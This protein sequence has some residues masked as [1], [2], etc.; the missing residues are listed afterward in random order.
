MNFKKIASLLVFICLGINFVNAQ[1]GGTQ[2]R[3]GEQFNEVYDHNWSIGA[4]VNIVED[5][6]KVI[7][8][9]IDPGKYWNFS[10]PFYVNAEY[11]LNNKFSFNA[12]ISMNQYNEGKHIDHV[13]I[14]EGHEASYFAVD[15]AAK[16]YFRDLIKTYMFD[17]YVFAGFGFTNIGNYKGEPVNEYNLTYPDKIE[18]DADGN[19]VVPAIGRMT[20]NAGIGFNFWFSQNWGLNLNLAGKWGIATGDQ[21]KGGNKISNQKQYALGVVYFLSN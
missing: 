1:L 11:Y 20:I 3:T 10:R 4:G 9:I 7:G 18:V 2:W 15:L 6:N 8:G 19:F 16:Y 17:P 12:M 21:D 13:Y 5:G 14:L